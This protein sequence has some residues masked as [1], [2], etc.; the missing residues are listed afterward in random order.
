LNVT[1]T[2]KIIITLKKAKQSSTFLVFGTVSNHHCPDLF[3]YFVFTNKVMVCQINILN[4]F[5]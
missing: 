5:L 3:L 4:L 2:L 1:P